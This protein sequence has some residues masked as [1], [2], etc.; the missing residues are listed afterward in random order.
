MAKEKDHT[1]EPW[2]ACSQEDG[3]C[4]CRE[5]WAGQQK[6]VLSLALMEFDITLDTAKAN[7]R[8]IVTCIN[9][10]VVFSNE[11]LEKVIDGRAFLQIHPSDDP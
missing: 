8:R 9:A 6:I 11:Q 10:C 1:P 7:T 3:G 2:V 4:N 5:I